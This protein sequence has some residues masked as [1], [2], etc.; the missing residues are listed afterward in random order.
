MSTK[1]V[2]TSMHL[3]T[4]IKHSY[5]DDSFPVFNTKVSQFELPAFV[6]EQILGLQVSVED[7]PPVAVGQAAQDL[8]EED[9]P[10][11]RHVFQ[12]PPPEHIDE[13]PGT[14]SQREIRFRAS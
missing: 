10:T 1:T 3:I 8:V 6:D 7:F 9:L 13:R 12:V 14:Q 5:S 4:Q 2:N 11:E